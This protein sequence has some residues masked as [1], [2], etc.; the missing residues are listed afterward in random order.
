MAVQLQRFR[1]IDKYGCL[2]IPLRERPFQR[3]ADPIDRRAG[4]EPINDNEKLLD[5]GERPIGEIDDLI[6]N[7]RPDETG[8]LQ[9]C[10]QI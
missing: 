9:F 5:A 7:H 10:R 6:A 4:S 2:A 8:G 3:F 1:S